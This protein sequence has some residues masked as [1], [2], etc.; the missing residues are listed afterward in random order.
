MLVSLAVR[1]LGVGLAVVA[2]LAARVLEVG[3]PF[4]MGHSVEKDFVHCN[5]I[6]LNLFVPGFPGRY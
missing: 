1:F 2:C 5:K 6:L 4:T 3:F